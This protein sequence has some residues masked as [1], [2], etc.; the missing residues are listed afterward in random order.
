LVWPP[1]ASLEPLF[2]LHK[3]AARKHIAEIKAIIIVILLQ[4]KPNSS[5]PLSV[6]D[7]INLNDHFH[8]KENNKIPKPSLETQRI[9]D[10]GSG[11]GVLNWLFEYQ[12]QTQPIRQDSLFSL[13]YSYLFY[14]FL[15]NVN[16]G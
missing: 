9:P 8:S 14:I 12:F 5:S 16:L 1:Q 13:S 6:I 10:P 4:S 15:S 11:E 2:F 7:S 3:K